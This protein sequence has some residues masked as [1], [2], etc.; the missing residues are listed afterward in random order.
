MGI[1]RGSVS[2][3]GFKTSY[4]EGGSRPPLIIKEPQT[5]PSASRT[6][7]GNLI[8]TFVYVTDITPMLLDFANTSHPAI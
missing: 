6:P 1:L 8:K 5:S 3:L 2:T 4:Y 7:G